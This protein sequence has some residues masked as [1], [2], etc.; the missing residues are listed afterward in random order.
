[1]FRG[2]STFLCLDESHGHAL[3]GIRSEFTTRLIWMGARGST[4]R[5]HSNDGV[6]RSSGAPIGAIRHLERRIWH[7]RHAE[8]N[9][10]R[11]HNMLLAWNPSTCRETNALDLNGG[12][13][14]T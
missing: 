5:R 11:L 13:Y 4:R 3:H 1:M 8:C 12:P 7:A 14:R 9:H 10:V 2:S 6:D